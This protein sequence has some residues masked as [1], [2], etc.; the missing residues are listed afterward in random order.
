[1]AISLIAA[2]SAINK[3]FAKYCM[4]KVTFYVEAIIIPSM[5]KI[6]IFFEF[7]A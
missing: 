4:Y 2:T 7:I 6:K 1:M 3:S 5:N